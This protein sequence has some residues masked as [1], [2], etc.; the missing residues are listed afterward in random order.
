MKSWES[1]T[2]VCVSKRHI[3]ERK[4]PISLDL[5]PA[6]RAIQD[7]GRIQER[8]SESTIIMSNMLTFRL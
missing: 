1:L 8:V 7:M 6:C 2:V 5:S 3:E 4:V